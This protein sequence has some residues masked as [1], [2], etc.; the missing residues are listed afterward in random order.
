MSA[1]STTGPGAI[2]QIDV[3]LNVEMKAR[4]ALLAIGEQWMLLRKAGCEPTDEEEVLHAHLVRHWRHASHV[5][6]E[7][8]EHPLGQRS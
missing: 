3:A 8:L 7:L 6:T 2:E 4:R 5:L 1:D